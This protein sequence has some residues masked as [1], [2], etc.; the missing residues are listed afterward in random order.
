MTKEYDNLKSDIVEALG[1]VIKEH[2]SNGDTQAILGKLGSMHDIQQAMFKKLDKVSDKTIANTLHI[3]ER[4]DDID[5]IKE[6]MG[7]MP[8]EF[9]C[10]SNKRDE[11][12]LLVIG[13]LRTDL[14]NTKR[15]MWGLFGV[16]ATAVGGF[17]SIVVGIYNKI[18]GN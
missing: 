14:R 6:K 17:I 16:L 8:Q 3:E 10:T 4:K 1:D 18:T 7:R 11:N 5:E 13:D 15:T 9:P 12:P 2:S